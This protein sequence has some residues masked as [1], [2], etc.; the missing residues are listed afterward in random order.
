MFIKSSLVI[1]LKGSSMTGEDL[2]LTVI[3][4]EFGWEKLKN[5]NNQWW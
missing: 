5:V 4:M 2:F 1:S 3:K